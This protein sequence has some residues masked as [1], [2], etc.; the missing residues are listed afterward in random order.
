MTDEEQDV[1]LAAIEFIQQREN[2]LLRDAD[3]Y[4]QELSES[5]QALL[6]EGDG[7]WPD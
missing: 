5:V 6:M 2:G 1:I 7:R 4:Y 3:K